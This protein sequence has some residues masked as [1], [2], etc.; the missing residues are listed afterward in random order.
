MKV[1]PTS[2]SLRSTLHS[3]V[4]T[5]CI[6][7][8]VA[9]CAVFFA[10]QIILLRSESP[11]VADFAE[12][13][14]ELVVLFAGIVCATVGIALL[15]GFTLSKRV[16]RLVA[17]PLRA[18]AGTVRSIAGGAD[19]SVR[20]EKGHGDEVGAFTDIFN[21]MLTQI[22][23]RD[24]ALREAI[25][26]AKRAEGELQAV[27]A[28]LIEAS[29]EAGM[30]EVATGVLHNVGNVLNSVNVSAT[31]ICEKLNPV[32]LDNLQRTAQLL[33]EKGHAVSDFLASDPKGRL[34]PGYLA[35]LAQHLVIQRREAL[36]ELE[37]LMKNI[38][39]IKE[40]VSMQQNYAR[41]TGFTEQIPPDSIVEDA[42][43]MTAGSV[44]RR[45]VEVI[46]K[47][48]FADA[49]AGE[50]HKVLQIL[51]NLIRNAQDALHEGGPAEKKITVRI[52]RSGPD[53]AAITVMDNGLGIRPENLTRIFSHGF[54]T[55]KDGHG[56]GLHSAALAA[57]EMG[58]CVNA[59]SDGPGL[60]ASFS[61]ELPLARMEVAA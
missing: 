40:I 59:H 11:S 7:P 58:G 31:V 19:Y 18:L 43:R 3:A 23:T 8:I 5:T 12:Q 56:F 39:H 45:G 48:E 21:E 51:V 44:R 28:R 57:H 47:Y 14:R 25:D 36:V 20:A 46:R 54:T 16:E 38:E 42:L 27:H 2:V 10:V 22:Q 50:R 15:V 30:A 29:R 55:R 17:E 6:V 1:S 26:E 35:E 49:V 60:G 53:A 61:L 24:S 52:H 4:F 32:R 37:L 41:V 9:A 33:R 13:L 34:I